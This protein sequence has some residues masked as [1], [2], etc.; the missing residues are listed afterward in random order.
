ML[1]A[2]SKIGTDVCS[3]LASASGEEGGGG[4]GKRVE[5]SARRDT[6]LLRF[7][8]LEIKHHDAMCHATLIRNYCILHTYAYLLKL[9][10]H[11]CM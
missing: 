7:P 2:L 9:L 10:L 6:W 11:V 3:R 4:E 1:I 5:I 8:G